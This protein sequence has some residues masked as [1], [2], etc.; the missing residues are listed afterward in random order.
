VRDCES[1]SRSIDEISSGLISAMVSLFVNG[2][3]LFF[4]AKIL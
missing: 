1:C 4:C 2:Y 3:S